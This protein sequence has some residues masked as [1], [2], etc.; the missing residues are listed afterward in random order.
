MGAITRAQLQS[1]IVAVLGVPKSTLPAMECGTFKFQGQGQK[2]TRTASF[3]GAQIARVRIADES[4]IETTLA[5]IALAA[6][7]VGAEIAPVQTLNADGKT[8]T[9]IDELNFTTHVATGAGLWLEARLH[10]PLVSI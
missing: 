2:P 6:R 3:V 10:V 1:F 5:R 7:A 4:M 9:A 8:Y